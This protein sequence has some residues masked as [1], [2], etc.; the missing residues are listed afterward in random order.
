MNALEMLKAGR[1]L[2]AQPSGWTK[3]VLA[4]DCRGIVVGSTSADATCFC[5]L[6]ALTRIELRTFKVPNHVYGQAVGALSAQ[7]PAGVP[8]LAEFNDTHTHA[9]VLALWDRAIAKLEA[10]CEATQ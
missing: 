2:I 4:R 3:G 7:M 5:S 8:C 6:G 10:Q 9:E 1:A